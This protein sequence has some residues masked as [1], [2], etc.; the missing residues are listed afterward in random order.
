MTTITDSDRIFLEAVEAAKRQYVPQTQEKTS[1]APAEP[2]AQEKLSAAKKLCEDAKAFGQLL[3]NLGEIGFESM[4][5]RKVSGSIPSTPQYSEAAPKKATK[6]EHTV[7]GPTDS[8]AHV[9]GMQPDTAQAERG[10]S[11]PDTLVDGADTSTMASGEPNSEGKMDAGADG[12]GDKNLSDGSDNQRLENLAKASS[13]AQKLR[14][15]S[16]NK[17]VPGLTKESAQ[18]V[19]SRFG[20]GTPEAAL[21]V[22]ERTAARR[23]TSS[24]ALFM[25]RWGLND[26]EKKELLY[27]FARTQPAYRQKTSGLES[28]VVTAKSA[29]E[30]LVK[31]TG[32]LPEAAQ[33]AEAAQVDPVAANIAIYE[34]AELIAA[35]GGQVGSAG[36]PPDSGAPANPDAGAVP[37]GAPP[38]PPGP[39]MGPP[40]DP[41]MMGGAPPMDPSMMGGAPPMP[42]GGAPPPGMMGMASAGASKVDASPQDIRD[43]ILAISRSTLAKQSAS[44][45]LTNREE[46]TAGSGVPSPRELTEDPDPSSGTGRDEIAASGSEKRKITQTL[47]SNAA[48]HSTDVD[49]VENFKAEKKETQ[50]DTSTSNPGTKGLLSSNEPVKSGF[51]GDLGPSSAHKGATPGGEGAVEG[52]IE[53][54]IS[55]LRQSWGDLNLL[56]GAEP[57][58]GSQQRP[59]VKSEVQA[60]FGKQ[61]QND[62]GGAE[63]FVEGFLRERGKAPSPAD[64]VRETGVTHET[65]QAAIATIAGSQG[66]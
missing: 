1:S 57:E 39:P 53:E 30:S 7:P 42:P 5:M 19:L 13:A 54:K 48:N 33:I 45:Q 58:S 20:I 51:E 3:Q 18:Q 10:G 16:G 11:R 32:E 29:V 24:S 12:G 6:A 40:M 43:A 14:I 52:T 64:V 23:K 34:V 31:A 65:A 9:G 21:G 44:D 61:A 38:M 17:F 15:L 55:A 22:L 41:S 46:P 66:V 28:D 36:A 8:T 63:A 26:P 49:R 4:A 62:S 37:G 50:V 56:R 59:S 47:G 27:A 2:S 35:T 25:S 60:L